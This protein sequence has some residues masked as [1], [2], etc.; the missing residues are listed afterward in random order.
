MKL[1]QQHSWVQFSQFNS[2]NFWN[3][4][5]NTVYTSIFVR[6]VSFKQ[7]YS[8]STLCKRRNIYRSNIFVVFFS[9]W[10]ENGA[11]RSHCIYYTHRACVNQ[12]PLFSPQLFNVFHITYPIDL[13][14][15]YLPLPCI[16]WIK[17]SWV[18]LANFDRCGNFKCFWFW[19]LNTVGMPGNKLMSR[20]KLKLQ[21]FGKKIFNATCPVICKTS[22]LINSKSEVTTPCRS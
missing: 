2:N 9:I 13:N 19:Y 3:T 11:I 6:K 8:S 5:F 20:R 14:K 4:A 1:S 7:T 21:A 16:S 10:P 18:L 22:N 17:A 12:L 15:L